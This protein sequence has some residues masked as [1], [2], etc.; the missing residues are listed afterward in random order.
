MLRRQNPPR[1]QPGGGISPRPQP[2]GGI[3]VTPVEHT[4]FICPVAAGP[5][6]KANRALLSFLHGSL[7]QLRAMGVTLTVRTVLRS[8]LA[9]RRVEDALADQGVSSFPALVTARGVYEGRDEITSLYQE[10]IA[11]FRAAALGAAGPAKKKYG[12]A[13]DL[14]GGSLEEFYAEEMATG[15]S[16]GEEEEAPIGQEGQGGGF[17]ERMARY[18]ER[19]AGRSGGAGGTR[20]PDNVGQAPLPASGYDDGGHGDDEDEDGGG[21]G[22]DDELM[23][24]FLENQEQSI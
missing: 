9:K 8:D 5:L 22:K 7:G 2:G 21:G 17:R 6:V 11:A 16:W 1:P 13:A 4:L 18:H 20:G 10:Q 14:A 19:R 15:E 24:K 3:S 23:A 12:P